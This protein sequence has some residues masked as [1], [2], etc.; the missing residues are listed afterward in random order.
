MVAHSLLLC[1]FQSDLP[2]T[3]AFGGMASVVMLFFEIWVMK[4]ITPA[5]WR[6]LVMSLTVVFVAFFPALTRF[7]SSIVAFFLCRPVLRFLLN[8]PRD[9]FIGYTQ[10]FPKALID[11][12][13]FLSFKMTCFSPIDSFCFHDNLS[14]L[15][16]RN[17]YRWKPILKRRVV[18]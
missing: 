15:K 18:I 13:T 12:P 16:Q 7:L 4:T 1:N 8:R 14:I 5:Q 6:L 2:I 11:F 9:F 17:I 3:L 10:C